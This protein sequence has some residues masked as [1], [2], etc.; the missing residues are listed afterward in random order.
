MLKKI[1]YIMIIIAILFSVL[2][3]NNCYGAETGE[4]ATNGVTD[5]NADGTGDGTGDENGNTSGNGTG[6]N[7]NTSNFTPKPSM[8]D[9]SAKIVE[10][11]LSVLTYVGIL[12]MIICISLIGFNAILGSAGEKAV[13]QEKAIGILVGGML[14]AS[15]STIAK[16]FIK[17]AEKF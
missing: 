17:I 15:G 4:E 12:M 13:A 14:L 2:I 9:K 8:G 6:I 1:T 10:V 3:P 11:I 5:E 16:V 7:I